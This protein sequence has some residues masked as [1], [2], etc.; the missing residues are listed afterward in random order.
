MTYE[1]SLKERIFCI[2]N[3]TFSNLGVFVSDEVSNRWVESYAEHHSGVDSLT[4]SMV[5]DAF[6]KLKGITLCDEE[7]NRVYSVIYN[8]FSS[9][10]ILED[11][12]S[13]IVLDIVSVGCKP[14]SYFI[15]KAK[16]GFY[17]LNR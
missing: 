14:N 10:G 3:E 4:L 17:L 2:V 1:A 8:S 6:S 15:N 13:N 9:V 12:V 7:R 16:K 5:S 11:E